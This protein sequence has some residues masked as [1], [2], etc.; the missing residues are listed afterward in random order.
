LELEQVS[1]QFFFI[2]IL[3]FTYMDNWV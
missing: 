1:R 3:L 2:Y